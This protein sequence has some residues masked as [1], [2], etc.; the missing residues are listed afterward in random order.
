MK[1][2]ISIPDQ[3]FEDAQQLAHELKISR[4][5]LFTKAIE[6]FIKERDEKQITKKLNE[7]YENGDS[8]LDTKIEKIQ[9]NSLKLD[10]EKW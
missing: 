1:T 7:I 5:E 3:V 2:A 8:K 6:G 10:K 9:I 4:S